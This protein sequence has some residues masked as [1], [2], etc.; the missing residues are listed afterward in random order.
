MAAGTV[1]VVKQGVWGDIKYVVADVNVTSGAN[2]TTNGESFPPAVFG[3]TQ[4]YEASSE[5][6]VAGRVATY[7]Y[8]NQKILVFQDNAVAAAAA[9]GQVASNTDLS[10]TTQKFRFVIKGI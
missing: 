1:T 10:A 8:T 7:D 2:Y 3:L 5:I 6:S 4:I 9:F